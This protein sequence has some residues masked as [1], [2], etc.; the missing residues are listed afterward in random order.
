MEKFLLLSPRLLKQNQS[1]EKNNP[2][3]ISL[4]RPKQLIATPQFLLDTVLLTVLLQLW[5]DLLNPPYLYLSGICVNHV[6]TYPTAKAVI[7]VFDT[8][9]WFRLNSQNANLS[10][11]FRFKIWGY[12]SNGIGRV[13][14]L[15]PGSRNGS[16]KK[17]RKRRH[18]DSRDEENNEE[19]Q[20]A[21]KSK[22]LSTS[23]YIFNNLFE[24]GEDSDI[25]VHFH[26]QSWKLHKFYLK[27]SQY[28]GKKKTRRN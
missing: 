6:L 3:A 28:F 10:E 20:P 9:F 5:T 13:W 7:Q 26:D 14:G 16:P 2:R 19:E 22:M 18:S 21:K 17:A 23:N 24:N 12:L 8:G 1:C 27:Q 4:V 15:I 25:L 11:F